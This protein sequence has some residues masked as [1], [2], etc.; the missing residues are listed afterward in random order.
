[1]VVS[2]F[3]A[4]VEAVSDKRFKVTSPAALLQSELLIWVGEVYREIVDACRTFVAESTIVSVASQANYTLPVDVWDDIDGIIAVTHQTTNV[5]DR[6]FLPDLIKSYRSQWQTC[7][8]KT[9]PQ[10][11]LK[12]G[13]VDGFAIRP[14]PSGSGESIKLTYVKAPTTPATVGTTVPVFFE[15]FFHLIVDYLLFKVALKDKNQELITLHWQKFSTSLAKK[16]QYRPVRALTY[17]VVN[18]EDEVNRS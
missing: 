9:S 10:V 16:A 5:L 18:V 17:D 2:D 8:G 1:M 13:T 3:Q 15:P 11:Y 6:A 4:A 12:E 7:G 14:A